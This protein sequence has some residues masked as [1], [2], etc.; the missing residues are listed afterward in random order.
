MKKIIR[1]LKTTLTGGIFFLVPVVVLLA[2]ADKA[3]VIMQ[4][5]IHPLI[6]PFAHLQFAGF[7]VQ[8]LVAVFILLSLCFVA[9]LISQLS[10]GKKLIRVIEHSLLNYIPGY[11]MMKNV[12]KNVLGQE[13]MDNVKMVLVHMESVWQLA[14]LMNKIEGGYATVFIPDSPDTHSGSICFIKQEHVREIEIDMKQAIKCIRQSGIGC[15][16]LLQGKL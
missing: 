2:I 3:F 5:I 7:A 4:K 6:R 15:D 11:R 1:V 14:Y 12:G 13:D 10:V 9:G 16:K 8:E